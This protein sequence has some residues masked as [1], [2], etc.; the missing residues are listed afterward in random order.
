MKTRWEKWLVLIQIGWVGGF[1]LL[2]GRSGLTLEAPMPALPPDIITLP[3]SETPAPQVTPTVTLQATPQGA[4]QSQERKAGQLDLS[5]RPDANFPSSSQPAYI[6][7]YKLAGRPADLR[8]VRELILWWTTPEGVKS[9][10]TMKPLDEGIWVNRVV[11]ESENGGPHQLTLLVVREGD[12]RG[13]N[14]LEQTYTL[15]LPQAELTGGMETNFFSANNASILQTEDISAEPLD[16]GKEKEKGVGIGVKVGHKPHQTF[17]RPSF[18][19]I[20]ILVSLVGLALVM[21]A[22]IVYAV[23]RNLPWSLKRALLVADEEEDV[24]HQIPRRYTKQPIEIEASD[25]T[26][27]VLANTETARSFILKDP[28]L[29]EEEKPEEKNLGGDLII[30]PLAPQTEAV[31]EKPEEE[32]EQT[33]KVLVDELS[34]AVQ[35][36]ELEDVP[37]EMKELLSQLKDTLSKNKR[38][39]EPEPLSQA[40]EEAAAAREEALRLE[41]ELSGEVQPEELEDVP[42]EMKELLSQLQSTLSKAKPAAE[43]PK[44]PAEPEEPPIP[45]ET[46]AEE[47]ELGDIPE[48]M[49]EMLAQLQASLAQNNVGSDKSIAF[50]DDGEIE[51]T[52]EELRALNNGEPIRQMVNEPMTLNDDGPKKPMVNEPMTLNDDGPKKQMVNEPMTLNDDGPRKPMI[53]EPM[54]LESARLASGDA[55]EKKEE[56]KEKKVRKPASPISGEKIS[57]LQTIIEDLEKTGRNENLGGLSATFSK[58]EKG[59]PVKNAAPAAIPTKDS[60]FRPAKQGEEAGDTEKLDFNNLSF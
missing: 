15:R 6:V 53:D 34:G 12:Q 35:P 21:L 40:E 58:I 22:A 48:E 28:E 11:V 30:E 8:A 27:E 14:I 24:M 49:R 19:V 5:I 17:L 18:P 37:E 43:E 47:E 45:I 60:L 46:T 51:L 44:A 9:S 55:L 2:A 20:V 32:L 38:A 56:K 36:E 16:K 23:V 50:T 41:K 33:E 57:E 25:R 59:V 10:I 54:T 52:D 26:E 4:A 3:A 13:V 7:K 31:E 29:E 39:D 1:S 42:E